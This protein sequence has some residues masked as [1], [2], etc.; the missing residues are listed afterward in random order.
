[1]PEPAQARTPLDDPRPAREGPV[2]FFA[3]SHLTTRRT[4]SERAREARLDAF[5]AHVVE[6]ASRLYILG[7]LFDFWFEYRHAIPAGHLQVFRRLYELRDAGVPVTFLAG[8]HDYWCV[9]FLSRELGVETHAGPVSATLQGRKIWMAHGDGLI[10]RDWGYRALRRV[11]RNRWCIAAYRLIH[12]DIGVPLAH[13]S[14]SGS[15][16]VTEQRDI[17]LGAYREQVILPKFREGYDAVLLGHI[18]V[19]I[20]EKE[21]DGKEFMF[22]G[23]WLRSFTYATLTN[24][25]FAHRRW[26]GAEAEIPG[27]ERRPGT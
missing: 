19:P 4:E 3:D 8:N 11:L 20:H 25:V 10:A 26:E 17:A 18:H 12:P 5:L 9:G 15:R 21:P 13:N 16:H 6:H 22:V 7:D 1:M 23:D 24:G 14:S 27:D 2:Y